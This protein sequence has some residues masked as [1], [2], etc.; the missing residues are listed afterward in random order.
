MIH[1]VPKKPTEF[2]NYSGFYGTSLP[3]YFVVNR[4]TKTSKNSTA[5]YCC[6]D[7]RQ[8]IIFMKKQFFNQI[9]FNI[10]KGKST[11]IQIDMIEKTEKVKNNKHE[12]GE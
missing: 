9:H 5:S 11:D 1:V 10:I 6:E 12:H 4:A 2:L 8:E 3:E 7:P